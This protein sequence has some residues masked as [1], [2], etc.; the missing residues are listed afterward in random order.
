M[1]GFEQYDLQGLARELP[2]APSQG[3]DPGYRTVSAVRGCLTK[4]RRLSWQWL[5]SELATSLSLGL[6]ATSRR[7][8]QLSTRDPRHPRATYLS[9]GNQLSFVTRRAPPKKTSHY[10]RWTSSSNRR[11]PC[12]KRFAA[13]PVRVA[14]PETLTCRSGCPS[15]RQRTNQA[16]SRK[17]L[18][19]LRDLQTKVVPDDPC[20]TNW[21]YGGH[22]DRSRL[23]PVAAA[24]LLTGIQAGKYALRRF[25]MDTR[26]IHRTLFTGL[27]P[28]G[29]FDYFAGNYR[30]S[31]HRCLKDYKVEIRGDIWSN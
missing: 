5:P 4:I 15:G 11:T 21:Q 31:Y 30:G 3:A 25:A 16:G 13:V 9:Q 10:R 1:K 18:R 29:R 28:P 22:P 7:T 12:L 17:W 8:A 27:T 6:A 19:K 26:P 24:T 23:L 20:P 14:P 2:L